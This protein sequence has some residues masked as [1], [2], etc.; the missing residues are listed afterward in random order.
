MVVS[1]ICA[2]KSSDKIPAGKQTKEIKHTISANKATVSP[3]ST[4]IQDEVIALRAKNKVLEE[5]LKAVE[6]S[7]TEKLKAN[8]E[9]VWFAR[10]RCRYPNHEASKR[11]EKSEEH[12]EAI[13]KL[14]GTD[15]DFHHGFNSGLLA[16]ARMFKEHADVKHI[17]NTEEVGCVQSVMKAAE[18]HSE[19]V[20]ASR[21]S[22]P[23]LDVD[24]FPKEN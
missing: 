22:F 16:A 15:G 19:K 2:P 13:S 8:F 9:L 23:N 1:S 21:R 4:S 24:E 11:I 17:L 18:K 5:A 3:S 10:N 7:A 14:R 6:E 12:R 20:D